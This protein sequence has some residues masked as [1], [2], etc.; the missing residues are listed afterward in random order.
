V[1]MWEPFDASARRAIVR[2]QHVAQ[3]F[4]SS[5]IGTEHIAFALAEGDDDVAHLFA[6]TLDREAIRERLGGVSSEPT[7]E[8]AFST[9]AKGAIENAFENAR[10]LGHGYIG[11]AHVALGVLGSSDPPPLLP[12]GDMQWLRAALDTVANGSDPMRT[13]WKRTSGA[14]DPH[15][16]ADAMMT[17]L[18]RFDDVARPGTRVSISITP[19]GG[20]QHAWSWIHEEY[21]G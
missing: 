9:G 18:L 11:S 5:F 7:K 20:A 16:A 17:A 6:K 15:P 10:R 4:G 12:G 8:M 19:P 13:V 2:A 21:P 1:G 14:D 3:L